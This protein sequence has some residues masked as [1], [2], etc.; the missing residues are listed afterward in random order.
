MQNESAI[1][2]NHVGYTRHAP[3]RILVSESA[4]ERFKVIDAHGNPVF[5]GALRNCGTW[6]HTGERMKFGDFSVLETPGTYMVTVGDLRTEPFA[7]DDSWLPRAFS[8]AVKS[9]YYQRSGVAL[10]ADR[11]GK[12]ARPAAHLDDKLL[13][14]A[15]MNRS[16]TRDAHGGWYDA[17]DYGKYIVNGGVSV[18]TLLLALEFFKDKV[19]DA[20]LDEEIRF[21]LDW[22]LRMQDDDGGV[23]FKVSPDHWDKFIAPAES[24]EQ[25][26]IVG[27]STTSTLNFAAAL[28]QAHVVYR[29]S[30]SAFAETGL[31]AAE[32]AFAWA[33]AHPDVPAPHYTEGSGP[34]YDTDYRDDFF[35]AAAMLFRATGNASYADEFRKYL[36]AERASGGL[37][38]KHTQNLGWIAL[39]L[40]T[41]D[42][43]LQA[44]ARAELENAAEKVYAQF[45]A[46]AYR[47][48]LDDFQ[49]GS[50]GML[51]NTAMTAAVVDLWK[52]SHSY[53]AMV[54]EA[55]D[56]LYG[57]NPVSV[58]FMTGAAWSSP[59]HPHHRISGGDGIEEPVPGFLVG[60]INESREDD[61][62]R[63]SLGVHYPNDI[64]G[65]SYLDEQK[66]FAVNEVAINWEAPLVFI[67]ASLL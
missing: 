29:E 54:S 44:Q 57:R 67:L 55:V 37:T 7:I 33:L 9:Y 10:D 17:G 38:W 28:A 35:W 59:K 3:K 32:R 41:Q 13:F 40:Q 66:A 31:K 11:A 6:R 16:G 36:G 27:K 47:I 24:V 46:S 53:R 26:R 62:S 64:P 18:A 51:A 21:E 1:R 34:Y 25:R 49:W 65:K 4:A 43:S 30:D 58:C 60:G 56:Y 20:R 52:P 15:S 14:H 22:F 12:W 48:P 42:A 63:R 5:E 2:Y 50:N 45:L 61:I 19:A 23:F 39:A 8:A